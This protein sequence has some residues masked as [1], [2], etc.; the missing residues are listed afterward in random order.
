MPDDV[1]ATIRML[2]EERGWSQARLSDESGV[3]RETI[4]RIEGKKRQPLA[5]TVLRLS[6]ALLAGQDDVELEHIVPAWPEADGRKIIGHG[7]RSRARRRQLGLSAAAV[8]AAA[9]VSE[10]TLS[11]F[12]CGMTARSALLAIE[13]TPHG[14]QQPILRSE[15]L[16]TALRF[17]DLA[18]HEDFCDADDWLDWPVR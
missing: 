1:G 2:R 18:E 12:E 13:I 11:R 7:A 5:D 8:A 4:A 6:A 16:A 17:V 9:G 15:R 3:A 14:D 10:S